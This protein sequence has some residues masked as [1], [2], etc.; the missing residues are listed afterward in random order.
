MKSIGDTSRFLG[1]SLRPWSGSSPF[2][3][4]IRGALS[5]AVCILLVAVVFGMG[6]AINQADELRELADF[7]VW[8]KGVAFIC[9]ALALWSALRLVAGI[10]D[11]VSRRNV[12]GTVVSVTERQKGDFLPGWVRYGYEQWRDRRGG[13]SYRD[14]RGRTEL[15]LQTDDGLQYWTIRD[16][17]TAAKF[18]VG[19][20]VS[21]SV[22][23]IAGHVKL[24]GSD[25]PAN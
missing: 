8:I 23:R 13:S 20:Q 19:E 4:I 16:Q 10:V 2:S 15:V 12:D 3:L 1:I 7:T 21:I 24:I 25:I 6:D 5:T 18:V 9:L 11:L 17:R 14:L 22:T